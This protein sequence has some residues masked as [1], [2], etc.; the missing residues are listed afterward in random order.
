MSGKIQVG[1]QGKIKGYQVSMTTPGTHLSKRGLSVPDVKA[2][3][4]E[5]ALKQ[6]KDNRRYIAT[7]LIRERAQRRDARGRFA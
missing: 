2:S 4:K 6:M 1:G 3:T 5:K 7:A